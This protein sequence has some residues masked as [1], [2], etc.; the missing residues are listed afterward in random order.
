MAA[1]SVALC[2]MAW[3]DPVIM[4]TTNNY[5][6]ASWPVVVQLVSLSVAAF[7]FAYAILRHRAVDLGFAVNRTLVYS[8][9]SALLV[10]LFGVAEKLSERLMP[11]GEHRAGMFVQVGIALVIFA[12]FHR[13]RGVVEN[14][15]ERVFFARWREYERRMTT[16]IYRSSFITRPTKLIEQTLEEISR[17]ADGAEVAIYIAANEIYRV[18]GGGVSGLPRRIDRDVPA[19]VA[20]RADRAL[21]RHALG[22][23]ALLL[24]MIQRG[25]LL[26]FVALGPKP[27]GAPYRPDEEE[28]LS[29]AAQA[30]GLDL[31]A[32]R[33]DELERENRKLAAKAALSAA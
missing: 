11:E 33:M 24:P 30:V 20:L 3:I 28:L 14:G 5:T 7:L 12:A 13:L 15:V 18:I 17:Y 9:L 2:V 19:V 26:G 23:S 21:Q 4:L 31:L 22:K 8:V 16:F 25:D 29:N 32:L 6:E 27:D 1:A 10:A